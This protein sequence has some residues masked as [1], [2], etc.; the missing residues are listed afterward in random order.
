MSLAELFKQN[1]KVINI[2]I[3]SF[4]QDL[5]SQNIDCIH[6]DWQPPAGGNKKIQKLLAKKS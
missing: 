4:A 2:G 6:V 1:T 5:K 3:P